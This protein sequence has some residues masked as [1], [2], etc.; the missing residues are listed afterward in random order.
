[1]GVKNIKKLLA[2]L[3]ICICIMLTLSGVSAEEIDVDS[4][5]VAE[6]PVSAE[7]DNSLSSYYAS[8]YESSDVPESYDSIQSSDMYYDDYSQDCY[9]SYDFEVD[10]EEYDSCG[11]ELDLDSFEINSYEILSSLDSYEY[12]FGDLSQNG[13]VDVET[14]ST[15]DEF[16]DTV[17]LDNYGIELLK[18][19]GFDEINYKLVD[20]LKICINSM[21][22]I[23]TDNVEDSKSNKISSDAIN[24]V[25]TIIVFENGDYVLDDVAQDIQEIHE[26]SEPVFD[27]ILIISGCISENEV[28]YGTIFESNMEKLLEF[29]GAENMGLFA[30]LNEQ[31]DSN[32]LN[33]IEDV[34][35]HG[36]IDNVN[37]DDCIISKALLGYYPLTNEFYLFIGN[38]GSEDEHD[39]V[40]NDTNSHGL[41][42]AY[43]KHVNVIYDNM[44]NLIVFDSKDVLQKQ[45]DGMGDGLDILGSSIPQENLLPDHKAIWTPLLLLL[46][47]DSNESIVNSHADDNMDIGTDGI[48]NDTDENYSGDK[49]HFYGHKHHYVPGN[50][51]YPKQWDYNHITAAYYQI[52]NNVKTAD[53]KNNTQD[54]STDEKNKSSNLTIGSNGKKYEPPKMDAKGSGPTYTLIYVIIGIILVALLFNSSY[55]K[56]DD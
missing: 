56:R 16:E 55:M 25:K 50:H 24:Q 34:T 46:Q 21:K 11:V 22:T 42:Y 32:V 30:N 35:L 44:L 29:V 17:I 39:H 33:T 6:S 7:L 23:I 13:N 12:E 37:L 3:L 4:S 20:Q 49:S 14:I 31:L 47:Q 52:T 27:G 10:L 41:E 5:V 28:Y 45:S 9:N 53:L 26:N 1:M 2:P 38:M 18:E 8:D 15:V 54:N 40:I 48:K 36:Q 19:N 51:Y 43:I